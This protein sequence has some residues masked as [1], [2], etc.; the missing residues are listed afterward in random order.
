MSYE[1]KIYC[2]YTSNFLSWQAREAV[3]SK[4]PQLKYAKVKTSS[5]L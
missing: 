3:T 5:I 1:K 2:T 4:I